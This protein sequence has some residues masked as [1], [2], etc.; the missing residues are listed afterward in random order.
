MSSLIAL[1]EA[2]KLCEVPGGDPYEYYK[3]EAGAKITILTIAASKEQANTAFNE[4][5]AKAMMSPYFRDKFGPEGKEAQRIWLLT[6]QDKVINRQ[7]AEK[8]LSLSKGSICVEV[9]H[10]NPDTLVGKSVIC[11]I[12]DEVASYRSGTG[13]PSTGDRIYDLLKPSVRTYIRLIPKFDENGVQIFNDDGEP[14]YDREYDGKI[15]SISSPRGKEGILHKLYETSAS[16]ANML[17]CRA[18][19]WVVNTRHTELSL[20]AMEPTMSDEKFMMEYGAQF[21]GTA[22]ESFFIRDK[23]MAAM[24]KTMAFSDIGKPG[25]V[26]FAHLDPAVNSN[27]YALVIVHKDTYFNPETKKAD[28]KIVVDH[29]KHW[30]PS[31]NKPIELEEVDNYLLSLKKRFHFGL[32][33][34]DSFS[35]STIQ[36]MKKHGLPAKKT[37]FNRIYKMKVYSELE[38][39][40]NTGRLVCPYYP[41]LQYELLELQRSWENNGFRVYHMRSGDGVCS[42]DIADALAGA[43]YN[44]LSIEPAR[45]PTGALVCSPQAGD[46]SNQIAWRSMQG[47]Q[48][49]KRDMDIINRIKYGNLN[50]HPRFI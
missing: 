27:K 23:V 26:Y 6:P 30:T 24:N 15:I 37:T 10:S 22:G 8:G 49:G 33:T 36:K 50:N 9:G 48:Y 18:A 19:T 21:S 31:A 7:L 17:M 35:E 20:R 32:V 45:L 16:N 4:I 34:Y 12:M 41:I 38:E 11:L 40:L 39:L 44:A 47:T 5:T 46:P 14:D 2:M 42:D 1:Y 13:G 29:I 43:C 25:I 28:F 3:L